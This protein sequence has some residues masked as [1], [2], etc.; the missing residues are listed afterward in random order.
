MF[1]INVGINPYWLEKK[2]R[3]YTLRPKYALQG[4]VIGFL[5][6]VENFIYVH[7]RIEIHMLNKQVAC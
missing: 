7:G 3:I 2:N 5:R 1:V 6:S 4:S